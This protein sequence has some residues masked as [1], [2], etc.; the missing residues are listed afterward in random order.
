LPPEKRLYT[1]YTGAAAAT[2]KKRAAMIHLLT[3][4]RDDPFQL[5]AFDISSHFPSRRALFSCQHSLKTNIMPIL[6]F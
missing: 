4:D 5:N 6:R 2:D 3:M 1:Y